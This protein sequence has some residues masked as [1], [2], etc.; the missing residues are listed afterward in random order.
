MSEQSREELLAGIG[1]AYY[2]NGKSKVEIAEEFNISR[3]HVARLLDEAREVGIVRIEIADPTPRADVSAEALQRLLGLRRVVVTRSDSDAV[4][5]RDLQAQA[6]S[7]L[8]KDTVTEGSTV[9]ISWSRT[10]DAMSRHVDTLP[11][12]EIVQ[13]AGALRVSGSGNSFELMQRLGR[14]S[15]GRT[16]PIWAPLVVDNAATA[17]GLRRNPDIAGA[18]EKA[19]TLDVAMV[20]IGSWEPSS[21]TVWNRVSNADRAEAV[22]AGAIAECSARLFDVDG[23]AVTTDLDARVLAV[24]LDQLRHTPEVIA[25]ARGS[26]LAPAVR[27]AAKGGFITTLVADDALAAELARTS[28]GEQDSQW[29]Q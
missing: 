19:D 6:A 28:D 15:G 13:L 27:A 29:A 25:I 5:G 4:L 24:T 22:A 7:S 18:L 2:L 23:R 11:K 3:F 8:L 17:A 16:W 21:S 14:I 10:M 12:C 9:G 1:R 20:A 26:Q